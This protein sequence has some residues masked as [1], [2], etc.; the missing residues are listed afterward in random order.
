MNNFPYNAVHY[1]STGFILLKSQPS[2]NLIC[3][4]YKS[5]ALPTLQRE[6]GVFF[7]TPCETPLISLRFSAPLLI[8][9]SIYQAP[10]SQYLR[11]QSEI[12]DSDEVFENEIGD[13]MA[14]FAVPFS[15]TL[16]LR[17][18]L[19]NPKF[20]HCAVNLYHY[21]AQYN[22]NCANK[23]LVN[24]DGS[25]MGFILMENDKLFIINE[26]SFTEP[27]DAL[28]YVLNIL[29]QNEAK[30]TETEVLVCGMTTEMKKINQL[31]SQYLPNVNPAGKELKLNI[32]DLKG[33]KVDIS[34]CLQ[35]IEI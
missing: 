26:L 13:Y 3:E 15:K 5:T 17:T 22:S 19:A 20:R 30:R 27:S 10:A 29:Q 14:L 1:S 35:L 21:L 33:Q 28:Y 6:C 24:F 31:L 11:L 16:P 32:T 12:S 2:G 23:L 8:P 9:K 4:T 25:Q 7:D 34:T 18:T